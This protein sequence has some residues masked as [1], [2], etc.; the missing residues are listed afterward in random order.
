[1]LALNAAMKAVVSSNI[2]IPTVPAAGSDPNESPPLHN[3]YVV[4]GNWL[5]QRIPR[6]S[7]EM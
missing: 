7:T 5:R 3:N 4:R 2:E 6:G 1:M